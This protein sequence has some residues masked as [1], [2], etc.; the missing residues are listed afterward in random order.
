MGDPA[1]IFWSSSLGRDCL[2]LGASP[3]VSDVGARKLAMGYL[4]TVVQTPRPNN[5]NLNN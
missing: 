5:E 3:T 4:A 1:P 2:R